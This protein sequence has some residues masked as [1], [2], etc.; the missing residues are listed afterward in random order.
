MVSVMAQ[1]VP[2]PAYLG[3]VLFNVLSYF[4][5]LGLLLIEL[6]RSMCCG[7]F[8]LR[9]LLV[10]VLRVGSE[11]QMVV[12]VT[13]A[14]TGAVLE[15]QSLFQ[16]KMVGMESIGGALV[17]VGML[18]ELGPVITGLMLAGRVGSSMAAEIG[19]MQVTEQVEALRSMNVAPVDYLVK[20]RVQATLIAMPI[21]MLEA[22][23]VGVLAAYCVGVLCFGVD[24]A[25]WMHQMYKFVAFGDIAVAMIKA[26][27][28]GFLI[29]LISCREGL[30]TTDG[31]V[32]VGRS[33]MRAMVYSAI[34]ILVMNFFLTMV[35]NSIFPM[36]A[37]K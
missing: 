3:I 33:T 21:L 37:L 10:Q 35:L 17:A 24:E 11:T 4:G 26:V 36:G 28:F 13:G 2:I 32:G 9:V 12:F 31:A 8:R 23:F 15:A 5:S 6:L 16:L 34:A 19:T 7:V 14:F 27:C 30:H 18:R 1:Q 20:P 22:V 29:S 25:Y